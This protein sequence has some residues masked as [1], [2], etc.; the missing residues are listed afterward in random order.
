MKDLRPLANELQEVF[1]KH[2]PDEPGRIPLGICFQLP[3]EQSTEVYFI[4]TVP[5]P[6]GIQMFRAVADKMQAKLQ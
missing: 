2:F 5:R 4:T 6:S 1:K 3:S